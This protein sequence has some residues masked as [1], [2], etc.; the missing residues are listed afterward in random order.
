MGRG[1]LRVGVDQVVIRIL[2]LQPPPDLRVGGGGV[3]ASMIFATTFCWV[4]VKIGAASPRRRRSTRLPTVAQP[5]GEATRIAALDARAR[6]T[7][8]CLRLIARARS[9]SNACWALSARPPTS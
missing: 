8:N 7:R 2:A 5:R 4:D 6:R 9:A 3:K 1:E